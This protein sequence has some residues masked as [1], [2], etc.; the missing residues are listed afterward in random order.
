MEMN[1]VEKDVAARV[2]DHYKGIRKVIIGRTAHA[3][4]PLNGRQ[5]MYRDK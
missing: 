3:T 1:C 4:V 5:C 2:K